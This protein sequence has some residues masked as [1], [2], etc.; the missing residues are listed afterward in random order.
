MC[1][2]AQDEIKLTISS[3]VFSDLENLFWAAQNSW[4]CF[5]RLTCFTSC[6]VNWSSCVKS[7]DLLKLKLIISNN[8]KW[9]KT[10]TMC[11]LSSDWTFVCSFQGICGDYTHRV[12]KQ[13]ILFSS[14][15][16]HQCL[17]L[18]VEISWISLL[19][20]NV[21][22]MIMSNWTCTVVH[23]TGSK[24]VSC[25]STHMYSFVISEPN[26][27]VKLDR[28]TAGSTVMGSTCGALHFFEPRVSGVWLV[29]RIQGNYWRP[30]GAYSRMW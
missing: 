21:N 15:F 4:S 9:V 1:L 11:G 22:I 14:L 24:I 10:S 6:E 16:D 2:L 27:K 25:R 18:N 26:R 20:C 17:C 12:R 13:P 8:V 23:S 28:L 7:V 19:F 5:H 3:G 30:D 29:G